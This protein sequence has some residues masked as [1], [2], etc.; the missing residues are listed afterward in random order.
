MNITKALKFKYDAS[1]RN[2]YVYIAN[3]NKINNGSPNA[4]LYFTY[5]LNVNKALMRRSQWP[6]RLRRRSTAARL[7]RLGI[8]IP[9]G[10]WMFVCCECCVL[11]GRVLCD[12]LITRPEESY[13]LWRVMCVI[14]KN[15]VNEEAIA[16]FGLQR[17]IKK[18]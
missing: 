2:M 11:S 13:R 5:I 14:S 8:R 18:Q 12:G 3:C 6:R 17:H 7:L 16:R 1:L 4:R 9:P 10:S 15:L